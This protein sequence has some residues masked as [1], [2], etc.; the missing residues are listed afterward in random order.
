M[1]TIQEAISQAQSAFSRSDS[2]LLDAHVL[3]C[4]IL[5]VNR[6]YLLAHGDELLSDERLEDFQAMV[7]RRA[8]GEPIAYILGKRGFYDLEFVVSPAVLIPR[9]ETEILLEKALDLTKSKQTISAVDIGTGSGAL[10]ITFATHMPRAK[11]YATDISPSALAI[12]QQN[13]QLNQAKVTFFQGNLAQALIE[14][15]LKV[16][17]LMANL[18]YIRRDEMVGLAVS[19]YEPHLALD[20]GEDGLDLIRELVEQIPLVC[21]AG[22]DILL[23]MG[24]EQASAVETIVRHKL[25]VDT[26]KIISDYAGFD[27]IAY[28]NL[29]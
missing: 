9:P 23:E 26:F 6:A 29:Q 8:A 22:C 15:N 13:A 14:R 4:Q 24:A 12:A 7:N 11:V 17:L 3:L 10:A 28:F 1:T 2:P 20:G 25:K 19:Q 21:V 5:G 27:R 18:P 16:G